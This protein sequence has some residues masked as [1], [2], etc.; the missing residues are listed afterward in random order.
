[1][2]TVTGIVL[3][4]S[5]AVSNSPAPV[6]IQTVVAP[7]GTNDVS[8]LTQVSHV[9]PLIWAALLGTL[10]VPLIHQLLKKGIKSLH[11][12]KH[13]TTNYAIAGGLSLVVGLLT[14]LQNSGALT[15]LHN[16][17]LA[18][19]LSA[20]LSFLLGQQVYG[21]FVKTNEKQTELDKLPVVV[22]P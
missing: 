18:T 11:D 9:D 17:I 21:F 6:A 8:L 20:S 19:I 7:S 1:M 3:S 15:R 2:P 4:P 14:D 13:R 5:P 22:N 16:P 12:P 10:V